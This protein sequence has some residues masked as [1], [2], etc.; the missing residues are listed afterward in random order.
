MMRQ[1]PRDIL[2]C[3]D[4]EEVTRRAAELFVQLANEGVSSTGRFTV[5]LS[6]GSTPRALYTL[7]ANNPFQEHVPWPKVHLFWGDERC[8]PPD[9]PDSNY[10]MTREALL[11]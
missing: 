7:L 11:D 2:V 10:R 8:V 3:R 5:A 4:P 6:G 1:S 9:H